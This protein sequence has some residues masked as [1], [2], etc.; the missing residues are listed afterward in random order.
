[1]WYNEVSSTK[2]GH[3]FIRFKEIYGT[4]HNVVEIKDR[5]INNLYSDSDIVDGKINNQPVI[6]KDGYAYP[7]FND[8][9]MH[10]IGYGLR[11]SQLNFN[12]CTSL[13]SMLDDIAKAVGQ[14]PPTAEKWLRGRGWNHDK[15]TEKRLPNRHDLDRAVAKGLENH[16]DSNE[17]VKAGFVQTS[18]DQAQGPVALKRACGHISVL[19]TAALRLC[20]LMN[21]DNS[22]NMELVKEIRAN[23]G[24]V[25]IDYPC[26]STA[27][28]S[29][30]D[31]ESSKGAPLPE[32]TGII[33]EFAID[34][35][36][37]S[38]Y[39]E[40]EL[41][42]FIARAQER[43]LSYGVGSVQSD[44]L[45]FGEDHFKMIEFFER[46][47]SE[48]KLKI[49]V[50]QQS[51]MKSK[52]D[53]TQK[54]KQ[55]KSGVDKMFKLGPLKALPDGSLG[56]R[57]AYMKQPY[58]DDPSTRGIL[59]TSVEE[60][61]GK[62]MAA[63]Q[64]SVDSAI[65]GIGDATIE[66][67]LDIYK[68]IN[69]LTGKS[70]RNSIIHSQIMSLEQ[71][72]KMANLKV[73]AL[74]QPIFLNYDSQIVEARVGK[75]LAQTSYAYRTMID[76]GIMLAFGSDAPVEDPNPL[77]CM[78]EAVKRDFVPEE[79]VTLDEAI[80]CYTENGAYFSYEQ[81]KKGRIEPG[82]FADIA[83]LKEKLTV[84]NLQTN[85]VISTYVAGEC[86]WNSEY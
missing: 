16:Q 64:K 45:Y 3:M 36:V 82:Q 46:L 6:N 42:K 67:L 31:S 55:D 52:E 38:N 28:I 62:M 33:R 44:D 49:R 53:I 21:S 7:A 41:E 47:E 77:L 57:T 30:C 84:D 70:N 86:V 37:P 68:N 24:E 76:K 2:G 73:G 9:H 13:E 66:I 22:I 63:S 26:K 35:L 25:D 74:V 17:F 15:F 51:Q 11:L 12:D 75:K 58:A 50:Y 27:D 19:N 5:L 20:G 18:N 65:H 81:N 32:L 56:S 69:T 40:S 71:I 78:L 39:S 4:H 8:S 54:Y 14:T 23:G 48:N 10:L 85:K 59:T 29:S 79:A 60:L 72:E 34:R 83:V 43:L 80:K 61:S 1:M